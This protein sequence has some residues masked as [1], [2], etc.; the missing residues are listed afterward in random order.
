MLKGK[1]GDNVYTW[2][3][4]TVCEINDDSNN[5]PYIFAYKDGDYKNSNNT[6]RIMLAVNNNDIEKL[7][8]LQQKAKASELED[9][10]GNKMAL[11]ETLPANTT[12]DDVVRNIKEWTDKIN[13]IK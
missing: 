4:G 9:V 13:A 6:T 1:Y 7:K 10:D 3:W 8:L 2:H 12:D 11:L 5:Y